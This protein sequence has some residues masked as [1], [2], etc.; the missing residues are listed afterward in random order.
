MTCDIY[1]YYTL[2][3]EY[4]I[5]YGNDGDAWQEILINVCENFYNIKYLLNSRISVI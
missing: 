1:I 2:F 4:N 3:T 5:E